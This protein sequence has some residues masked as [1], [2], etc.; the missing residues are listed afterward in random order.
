MMH[1]KIAGTLGRHTLYTVGAN[2]LWMSK[3]IHKSIAET[4]TI[5]MGFEPEVAGT[6]TFSFDGLNSFDPTSY[7]ML[8]D[9]KLGTMYNVRNGDYQFTSD[10][11]R[12][13][14][15]LCIA[16]YTG[17]RSNSYR[18][19][20]QQLRQHQCNPARLCQLELHNYR[21]KQ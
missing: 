19:K 3:N 1:R 8:E 5:T 15:A 14:G 9:R 16:L 6:Y 18:R 2:N 4:S 11:S 21:C 20:L 17:S 7:I 10:S 13:V 12:P